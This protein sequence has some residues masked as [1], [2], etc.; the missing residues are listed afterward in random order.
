[1]KSLINIVE[2]LIDTTSQDVQV[3]LQP[4]VERI[5]KQEIGLKNFTVD[6]VDHQ[7]VITILDNVFRSISSNFTLDGEQ[8]HILKI[9]AKNDKLP[10]NA[11]TNLENIELEYVGKKSMLFYNEF[12]KNVACS[13]NTDLTINTPHIIKGKFSAKNQITI[14]EDATHLH[15]C[16]FDTANLHITFS[17]TIKFSKNDF[18]CKTLHIEF[19]RGVYSSS[20][21]YDFLYTQQQ[22]NI[23]SKEILN[24]LEKEY[25]LKLLNKPDTITIKIDD[26]K[27]ELKIQGA[28]YLLNKFQ[29]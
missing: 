22:N 6:V 10:T 8:Y 25:Q 3:A 9:I 23:A 7:F 24:F 14:G 17:D 20:R 21:L 11:L 19:G 16:L 15:N 4:E 26:V 29:Y 2:K 12:L 13:S 28:T 18:R 27:F 1:M 5:L